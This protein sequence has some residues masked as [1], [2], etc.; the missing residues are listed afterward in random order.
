MLGT[1][2]DPLADKC[3]VSVLCISLTVVGLIPCE[4]SLLL[5]MFSDQYLDSVF[6]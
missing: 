5:L 3:L 1:I 6:F 4:E 2:L